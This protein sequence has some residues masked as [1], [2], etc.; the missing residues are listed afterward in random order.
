MNA[1]INS[2]PQDS[3]RNKLLIVEDERKTYEGWLTALQHRNIDADVAVDSDQA[4]KKLGS[5]AYPLIILDLM[6]PQ[7]AKN[8]PAPEISRY[9]V[10]I[11]ILARIRKGDFAKTG[12]LTDV[13]VVVITAI[14]ESGV[15]EKLR[16]LNAESIYTKPE[17][18]RMLAEHAKILLE[19]APET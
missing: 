11:E 13:P 5:H 4:I 17:S 7:G 2:S 12:T 16:C 18:A 10:G 3:V 6:L 14:A 1:Q 19:Q 8:S 9:D 15:M